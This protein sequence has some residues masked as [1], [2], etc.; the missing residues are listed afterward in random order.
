MHVNVYWN[1]PAEMVQYQLLLDAFLLEGFET[2]QSDEAHVASWHLPW[3]SQDHREHPQGVETGEA[4]KHK[5]L[6]TGEASAV[7]KAFQFGSKTQVT[8]HVEDHQE[9]GR[10][11]KELRVLKYTLADSLFVDIRHTMYQRIWEVESNHNSSKH[12][13][14]QHVAT[15]L[16]CLPFFRVALQKRVKQ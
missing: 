16:L 10:I 12:I 4:G 1:F 15:W 14:S 5:Q 7:G 6:Y 11:R 2:T 3:W 13:P 8:S 9:I